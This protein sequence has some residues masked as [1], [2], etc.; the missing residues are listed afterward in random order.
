M[1]LKEWPTSL[2]KLFASLVDLIQPAKCLK[3]R[4][5]FGLRVTNSHGKI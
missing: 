1:L 3:A 2:F 5:G 4:I